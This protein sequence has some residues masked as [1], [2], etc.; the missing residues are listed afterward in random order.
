MLSTERGKRAEEIGRRGI[1]VRIHE[2]DELRI[3]VSAAHKSPHVIVY[4]RVCAALP[5][6]IE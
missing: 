2:W 4:M 5:L 1:K 3:S 6:E